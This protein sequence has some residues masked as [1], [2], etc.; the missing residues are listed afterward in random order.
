M[1]GIEIVK[2]KDTLEPFSEEEKVTN[3]I[4]Q[5]GLQNGV[6]LYPG[7]QVNSEILFALDLPS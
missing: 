7:A 3:Q 6:F 1:L 4:M 5:K 2:D